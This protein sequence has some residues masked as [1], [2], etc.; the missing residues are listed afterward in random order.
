MCPPIKLRLSIS[1]FGPSR[2][3]LLAKPPQG[4]E[5]LARTKNNGFVKTEA[6]SFS[7]C[8]SVISRIKN[9]LCNAW[10]LVLEKVYH[11]A[12]WLLCQLALACWEAHIQGFDTKMPLFCLSRFMT[13]QQYQLEN[14]Y[15]H[16][17][18]IFT[19][20]IFILYYFDLRNSPNPTFRE[21]SKT[22]QE[23]TH[24]TPAP[25]HQPKK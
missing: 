18:F 6:H 22:H 13:E 9:S 20:S 17:P 7:F 19:F 8:C 14:M 10:A 25:I 1:N 11:S 4:G 2:M 23:L 12:S 16:F 3:G 15:L 21:P 24:T 5:G